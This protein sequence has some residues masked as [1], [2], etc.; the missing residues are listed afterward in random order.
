MDRSIRLDVVGIDLTW[1]GGVVVVV[2]AGTK[3]LSNEKVDR[4]KKTEEHLKAKNTFFL[5]GGARK[6]RNKVDR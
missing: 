5:G 1:R 3:T 4:T 2:V 6:E